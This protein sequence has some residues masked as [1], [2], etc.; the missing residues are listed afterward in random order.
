MDAMSLP[1]VLVV[2][3]K[4]PQFLE[5]VKLAQKERFLLYN[6]VPVGEAA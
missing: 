5:S 1:Q 3:S 4:T 6:T 2:M